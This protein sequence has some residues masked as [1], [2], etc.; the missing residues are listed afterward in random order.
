VEAAAAELLGKGAPTMA[1]ELSAGVLAAD[2]DPP[3]S[4]FNT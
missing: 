3:L 2:D 1:A 4:K